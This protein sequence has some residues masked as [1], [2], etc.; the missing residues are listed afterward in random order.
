VPPGVQWADPDNRLIFATGPLGGT[1]IGGSGT[2]TVITKGPLT[3]GATT[4]QANGFFGAFLKFCGYDAVVVQGA[5]SRWLYLHISDGG[6]ELRD[7]SHLLGKDTWETDDAVK[8]ELKSKEGSMSVFGIGPAGE[9]LVKF[10]SVAGDKGHVAGHNGTGAVMGS[11]KLK[12]IA[13]ARDK[14]RLSLHDRRQLLDISRSFLER[15]KSR[16]DALDTFNWGTL[17]GVVNAERGGYLPIKNYQTNVFDISPEEL[18][19]FSAEYIRGNFDPTPNPCWACQLHHCHMMKITEGPY[20]GEVVE[21]PEYEG[22]SAWGSATGQTQVASTMVISNEVDKLGLETNEAGWLMG[23]VMECYEKGII[24][25]EDTDLLEMTWGNA[26][27]TMEMLRKIAHR[28]G[29]GDTLAEGTM[30]AAN[31]IGGEAPN[32]A[33]HTMKGNTPRGHDHR[34]LWQE[35]FDTCVSSTGTIESQRAI[36]RES[37]GL[38]PTGDPF[39][40]DDVVKLTTTTKGAMQ[41]EDALGV[42]RFNTR[43]DMVLL[44][45][46]VQAATGWNYTMD[47]AMQM[48]RRTVNLL[49]AFN[50]RHGIG[51]ELD[52]PSPRYGSTPA[53]GSVKGVGIAPNWDTMVQDYYEQMGWDRE[54]SKP[55]PETLKALSLDSVIDD[56]WG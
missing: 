16:G 9:N 8:A 50:L 21:E 30:R 56:L 54:T 31:L 22:F 38:S 42:C 2:F 17:Q 34:S 15:T 5:A 19:K 48:G 53:D 20:E 33:I 46:A 3:N 14:Q 45:E 41:F 10:A 49:K 43:T 51:P 27:A 36:D 25:R 47:D 37:F 32:L 52:K 7:A 1:T 55:L 29:F 11:K 18:D 6:A 39:D 12:V 28:E 13:V 35:M 26:E 40:P 23:L 24:N 44:C 4:T